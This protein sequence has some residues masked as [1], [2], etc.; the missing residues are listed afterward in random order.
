MEEEVAPFLVGH[1]HVGESVERLAVTSTN[2]GILMLSA[3]G[4]HDTLWLWSDNEPRPACRIPSSR[5]TAIEALPTSHGS[6]LV[7]DTEGSVSL[8]EVSSDAFTEVH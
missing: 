1:Y 5:T 3:A 6:F 7:C 8:L 2:E 4:D